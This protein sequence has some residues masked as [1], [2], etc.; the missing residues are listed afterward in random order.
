MIAPERARAPVATGALR[1]EYAH[2][3]PD[4]PLPS[5][6]LA[7]VT[8]AEAALPDCDPRRIHVSL[9]VL[10][11]TGTMELWRAAGPVELGREGPIRFASGAEYLAGVIEL[12]EREHGGLAGAAEAAYALVSSFQQRSAHPH[13]L[14]AWNY[15]DGINRGAADAERYKQF[16]LGRAA[17]L[18]ACPP[19][20]Y[21]AATAIGRRD[22]SPLLQVFWL[23]ARTAGT[24]LENPRQVSAYRYPRR[25]GPAAPSFSRAML[26]PPHLL[27]ISGT[28]SITGH[29][30]RHPGSLAEQIEETLR[31]LASVLARAGREHPVCGPGA[32]ARSLLKVYLRDRA[33]AA[34]AAALLAER[35][36]GTPLLMLEADICR[37]EL[38]VEIDCVHHFDVPQ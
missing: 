29:A 9:G 6:A 21:P 14:R 32:R 31:N 11:G 2:L 26:I 37:A 16:C 19:S 7:A 24:S 1:I 4:E 3:A 17:G 28:A 5:D 27:L 38:L 10:A 15:F 33:S 35:L 18:G 25:Y 30:S 36:P 20:R 13:L 22:G 34:D 23:A 12:D 8:F